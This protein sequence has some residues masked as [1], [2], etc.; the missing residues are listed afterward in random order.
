[1]HEVKQGQFQGNSDNESEILDQRIATDLRNLKIH[2]AIIAISIFDIGYALKTL[3]EHRIL[4]VGVTIVGAGVL[5]FGIRGALNAKADL[6][7]AKYLKE[8]TQ[9]KG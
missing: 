2:S 3:E 5:A 1:M 6:T 7:V 9:T 4:S 8:T